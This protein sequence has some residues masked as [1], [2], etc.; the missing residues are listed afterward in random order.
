MSEEKKTP[1]I[2]IIGEPFRRG[3]DI[4]VRFNYED[5]SKELSFT[6]GTM[7]RNDKEL[8]NELK[9]L[10]EEHRPTEKPNITIK[11]IDW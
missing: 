10:Y 3:R 7:P 5:T 4:T 8:E 2:E 11:E 1:K 6:L 9:R